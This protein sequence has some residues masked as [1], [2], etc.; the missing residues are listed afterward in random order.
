M[1]VHQTAVGRITGLSMLAM[2][3]VPA[4]FAVG[5][6]TNPIISSGGDPWAF[7]WGGQYFYTATNGANMTV[8]RSPWL[9]SL[10][11]NAVVAWAPPSEMA[12][13]RDVWAPEIH[14]IDGKWYAY[15]TATDGPLGNHRMFVLEGDSQDPQGS[16]TLMGQISPPGTMAIDGT[17]MSYGEDNYFIWSGPGTHSNTSSLYIA[18]MENPWTLTSDAPVEISY[19][20]QTWEQNGQTINEAPEILKHGDDIFLTYSA[21]DTRSVFYAIGALK[22]TG[23]DPMQ[24][25]AWTKLDG[26]LFSWLNSA[27]VFGPGHASFV[28][29]P[30]GAQDWIVYHAMDDGRGNVPR[31]VR[32]QPFTWNEDGTPNFGKPIKTG[33][34]IA[35]PSGTPT[36]TFIPNLSFERGGQGWLDNFHTFGDVGAM[37]NDGT[38][39]AKIANGDGPMIGYLGANVAGSIWQDI[40]PLTR[41]AYT[42][43]IGLAISDDQAEL[44]ADHPAQFVLR[45]IGT[46]LFPGG[47]AND[48]AVTILGERTIDSS[49]LLASAFTYFDL[50]VDGI[51]QDQIGNWLRVEIATPDG[52]PVGTSD[53]QVKLDLMSLSLPVNAMALVPEPASLSL[54][55][56][57]GLALLQ[58]R[59]RRESL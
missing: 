49:E 8:A 31:D 6:F 7:Q 2:A 30:D 13:N 12:Y 9:P 46:G 1:K 42:L 32:T 15:L 21:N 41:T 5:Q 50:M 35:D 4:S 55:G 34:S 25:S 36:V 19:P 57:A 51:G 33:T 37:A 53:W 14:R 3:L 16:Y 17:V 58:R 40:G 59:V 43:S 20:T 26:P 44:A 24:A 52:L 23:S 28:K 54:L 47:S 27:G 11:S 45:L 39:F 38:A 56:L 18:R 10:N 22:L 48:G 29:S